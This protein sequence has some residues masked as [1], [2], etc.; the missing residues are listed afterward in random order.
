MHCA[1]YRS[2]PRGREFEKLDIDEML[3]MG[4]VELA[5]MEWAANTVFVLSKDW[6]LHFFVYYRKVHPVTLSDLYSFPRMDAFTKSLRHALVFSTLD[7]N[8]SY[9]QVY[10]SEADHDKTALTSHHGMFRFSGM[11][12]GLCNAPGAFQRTVDVKLSPIN[13]NLP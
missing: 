7:T 10:I 6:S 13:V 2:G 1:W 12:F 5:E 11:Q 8:C 9:W 4:V 3:E